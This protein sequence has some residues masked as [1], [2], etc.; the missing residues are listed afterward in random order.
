MRAPSFS[1][2]AITTRSPPPLG[3][4][5]CRRAREAIDALL[6][7]AAEV[8][9][10]P[11]EAL[12]HNPGNGSF[13]HTISHPSPTLAVVADAMPRLV[14]AHAA[15]LRSDVA[16]TRLNGQHFIRTDPNTSDTPRSLGWHV[17][18]AFLAAHE[19]STPR[20]VY[21]RSIVTLSENGVQPGGG[22]IMISPASVGVTRAL[23]ADLLEEH[24][25]ADYDGQE[26]RTKIVK[27]LT[28]NPTEAAWHGSQLATGQ[29]GGEHLSEGIEVLTNEGDAVF[30]AYQQR[31]VCPRCRLT[32]T[33]A[34]NSRGDVVPHRLARHQRPAPL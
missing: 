32:Q 22:A 28:E 4:A 1:P 7:P 9:D 13:V 14:E 29:W 5:A 34:A 2:A 15:S 24:G 33:V 11:E 21:T 10:V 3:L 30:C 12:G 6:G 8:C 25:D 27:T 31:R 16:N 17:D 20:E 18:N 23:V 19:A 26:W